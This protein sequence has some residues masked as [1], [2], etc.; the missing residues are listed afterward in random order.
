MDPEDSSSSCILSLLPFLAVQPDYTIFLSLLLLVVL[1]LFSALISGSEVAFFTLSQSDMREY[2]EEDSISSRRIR[3]LKNA[4]RRLLATILIANN[5]INIAIVIISDFIIW[6]LVSEETFLAWSNQ[7]IEFMNAQMDPFFIARTF[8]FLITVLGVTFLLVLFGEVAPKVYASI[9]YK[10]LARFMSR[11][12]Y[13]LSSFLYPVSNGLVSM[14]RFLEKRIG[15]NTISRSGTSRDDIDRAIELTVKHDPNAEQEMDILK[16]IVKFGD[17]T[18][19]QIMRSRVDVTAVEVSTPFDELLNIIKGSGYSRIPVYEEDLDTIIGILYVKDLIG[20]LDAGDEFEWNHLI[21]QEILYV[22]ENKKINELL[23]EF[24]SKR[25][26]MGIVVD[27]YG[28]SAGIVTLE[29][30]MEEVIGDIKDEFDQEEEV[31][32]VKLN[33]NQFIFEGKSLLNDVCRIVGVST[34]TFDPVKGDADS[35]AGLLLEVMGRMP[36]EEQEIRIESFKFKVLSVSKRRI[37]RVKLT[38]LG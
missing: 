11:P 3:E 24:Q 33:S 25:L 14:S 18:V 19:K 22:P 38:L 26:H 35:I 37:E 12:L 34:D 36:V 27:E 2:E 8:N 5:F 16:S 17:V 1:L 23:K 29:D 6:N 4:P 28:G 20:F 9:N 32:F 7:L 31:E 30:V 10:K 13:V 15:G 21:R